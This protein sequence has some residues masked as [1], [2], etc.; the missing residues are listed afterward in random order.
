MRLLLTALNCP[1]GEVGAN[2]A[3]HHE[4]LAE[5]KI[6]DCDLVL[7]PEMSLTGYLVDAALL[8][9]DPSVLELIESTVATPALCFGLVERCESGKGPYITQLVAADGRLT[10][11]HRKAGLGEGEEQSFQPGTPPSGLSI[12]AGVAG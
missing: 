5:G 7:L 6:A 9:S 2:L 10:A 4:L 8:L 11:V 12:I 1:K 3:R